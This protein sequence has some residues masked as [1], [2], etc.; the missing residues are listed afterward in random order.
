[1]LDGLPLDQSRPLNGLVQLIVQRSFFSGFF[2]GCLPRVAE[3]ALALRA[4]F[5]EETTTS[6]SPNPLILQQPHQNDL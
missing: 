6:P 3:S 5:Q 1:M 4:H 2:G